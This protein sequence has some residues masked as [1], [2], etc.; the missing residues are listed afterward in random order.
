MC[1]HLF[2]A[3]DV[4]VPT[5]KWSEQDPRFHVENITDAVRSGT[6][7]FSKS[8][9]Y[10]LASHEGCGCG[11]E[12]NSRDQLRELAQWEKEWRT[13]SQELRNE[14]NWSP[15]DERQD[16]ENR[17]KVAK[18]LA[19]LLKSLLERT[20]ELELGVFMHGG[21][22]KKPTSVRSVNPEELAQG[23]PEVFPVEGLF[24]RVTNQ[25]A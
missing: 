12:W 2:L 14:I 17:K 3:S 20:N 19:N 4:E 9:V 22:E 7:Y 15:S 1:T 5:S 25:R 24:Y 21:W 13:L 6:R 18:D 8:N 23:R 10:Y 11:F 16:Y